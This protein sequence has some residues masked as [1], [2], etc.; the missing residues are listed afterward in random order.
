[1]LSYSFFSSGFST[2]LS[3]SSVYSFHHYLLPVK[4]LTMTFQ[5]H[6]H[7]EKKNPEA[8]IQSEDFAPMIGECKCISENRNPDGTWAEP[9]DMIWRWKYIMNDKEVS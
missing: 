5:N 6:I 2:I 9:V 7:T 4:I 8:P 3:S 1:M